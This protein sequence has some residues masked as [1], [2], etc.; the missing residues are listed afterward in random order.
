[1]N[2]VSSKTH[3]AEGSWWWWVDRGVVGKG[4][5][6]SIR[7]SGFVPG[8]FPAGRDFW[9]SLLEPSPK[10]QGERADG[11]VSGAPEH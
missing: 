3:L 6:D 2:T 1:M 9:F 11:I 7:R 8:C 5:R 10:L 4:V